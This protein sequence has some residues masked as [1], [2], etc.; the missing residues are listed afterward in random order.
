MKKSQNIPSR[1]RLGA[2]GNSVC[3]PQ[4]VTI[5]ERVTTLIVTNPIVPLT[6]RPS[7][8]ALEAGSSRVAT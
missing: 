2:K 6:R 5:G 1:S 4:P 3:V 8:A 7:T